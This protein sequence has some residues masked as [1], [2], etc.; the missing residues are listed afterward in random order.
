MN[1]AYNTC[2]DMFCQRGYTIT[3]ESDKRILATKKDGEIIC[4]YFSDNFKFNVTNL[5]ECVSIMT[6]NGIHHCII[7]YKENITPYA[8]KAI[9]SFKDIKIELFSEQELNCNITKH[10]LQPKFEL[11]SPEESVEFKKKWSKFPTLKHNDPISLFYNFSIG[12][13]IR[14]TRK[15]NIITYRIVR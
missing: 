8:S 11:L 5:E 12:D 4:A 7:I 1:R 10:V 6:D 9:D 15:N 3:E 14:V 2:L 13:V